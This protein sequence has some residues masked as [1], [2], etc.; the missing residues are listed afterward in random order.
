MKKSM[1]IGVLAIIIVVS[2][3]VAAVVY[4]NLGFRQRADVL[5]VAI[6]KVFTNVEQTDELKQGEMIDWGEVL[7]GSTN[8][9]D[10]W[11]NNT[12]AVPAVLQF[13]Y[14]QD[15][16]PW[17]WQNYWNY[18]GSPLAPNAVVHVTITLVVPENVGAGHYEWDSWITAWEYTP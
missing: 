11:I 3:L 8:N 18:D 1:L 5:P 17:D 2:G 9:K 6:V 12:G 13:N 4:Y 10:L 16:M 15:Q 7:A 14:R